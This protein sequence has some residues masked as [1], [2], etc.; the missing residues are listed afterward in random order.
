MIT[1]NEI[2][3]LANEGNPEPD[4]TLQRSDAEWAALLTPEQYHVT[5][6]AGTERAFSNDMCSRFEPGNYACVCC[7]TLLFDGEQKFESG[8]GWPS[9]TQP[10]KSN[11]IAYHNDHS[12]GRS[13][14]ETTCNTCGAHLGHVFPDGPPPSGLRYCMNAVA[15][16]KLEDDGDA[17][18]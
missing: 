16:H 5:R 9:F 1:W 10:V 3:R 18:A 12:F 8:S 13:R 17:P 6:Q 14:I 15:L 4:T 7:G 11:V 2:C